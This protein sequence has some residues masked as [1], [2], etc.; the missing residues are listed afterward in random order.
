MLV[1]L[2]VGVAAFSISQ[3][4]VLADSE[5]AEVVMVLDQNEVAWPYHDS[6]RQEAVGALESSGEAGAIL[7]EQAGSSAT[8]AGD[9]LS[10]QSHFSFRV[11]SA[12]RASSIAAADALADW[13]SDR[14]LTQVR[15]PFEDELAIL[16]AKQ[17]DLEESI[18]SQLDQLLSD[19][20]GSATDGI[21][22]DA[23]EA[24]RVLASA[25]YQE[26]AS[27]L[28][29]YE[30]LSDELGVQLDL[31]RPQLLPAAPASGVASP[32]NSVATGI[33]GVAAAAGAL[34]LLGPTGTVDIEETDTR[35]RTTP[36]RRRRDDD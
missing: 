35:S 13:L 10:G 26:L 18:D 29:A 2:V 16:A 34:A 33:A 9:L 36:R 12:D 20:N 4:T 6:V 11:T 5:V 7:I 24:D 27:E 3:A 15:T 28:A 21:I 19:S 8:V 23:G 25:R 22:D 32:L 31:L 17:A 30:R 1:S 14:S